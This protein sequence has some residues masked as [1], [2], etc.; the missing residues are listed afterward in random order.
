[1]PAT[2][3]N[4]GRLLRVMLSLFEAPVS[5]AL[6]MS[7]TDGPDARGAV[8]GSAGPGTSSCSKMVSSLPAPGLRP[9]HRT[10]DWLFTA[11]SASLSPS[12]GLTPPRPVK[13]AVQVV[14]LG[15]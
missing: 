8:H 14:L 7:G 15:S 6:V 3:L 2:P 11:R 4:V 13:V 5:V 10:R 9:S 1:M 12:T